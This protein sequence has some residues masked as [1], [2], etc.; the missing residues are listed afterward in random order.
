MK[1][2]L[3]R[4]QTRSRAEF[5]IRAARKAESSLPPEEFAAV[6]LDYEVRSSWWVPL[7]HKIPTLFLRNFLTRWSSRHYVEKTRKKF[8]AFM[9]SKKAEKILVKQMR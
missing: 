9:D 1:A 2:R 5:E 4:R 3:S 6:L 7:I 8:K